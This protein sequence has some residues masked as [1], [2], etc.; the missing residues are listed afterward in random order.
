VIGDKQSSS[1][2]DH[3]AIEPEEFDQPF[4]VHLPLDDLEEIRGLGDISSKLSLSI[5]LRDPMLKRRLVLH[6]HPISGD[7]PESLEIPTEKV[8]EFSHRRELQIR[9][10]VSLTEDTQSKEAGLPELAGQ[11]VDRR[12]FVVKTPQVFSAFRIDPMSR[13]EARLHTGYSGALIH[14]DYESETMLEEAHADRPVA[15]CYIAEKVFDAAERAYDRKLTDLLMSEL[16]S[17]ILWEAKDEILEADSVDEDSPLHSVLEQLSKNQPFE[18]E[19]LKK[20]LKDPLSL[21]AAVQECT[22]IVGILGEKQ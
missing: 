19:D 7:L 8:L 2:T 22:D 5:S 9:V 14:V 6:E 17:A 13:E 4:S 11:W 21:R 20:A 15:K 18:L 12:I 10:F 3:F 16:V 1:D